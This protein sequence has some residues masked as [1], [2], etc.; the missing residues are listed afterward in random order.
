MV[1]KSP[2]NGGFNRKIHLYFPASHVTRGYSS[3]VIAMARG[4]SDVSLE[5]MGNTENATLQSLLREAFTICCFADK[6]HCM[7]YHDR[8]GLTSSHKNVAR[9]VF[10]NSAIPCDAAPT[11]MMNVQLF[12]PLTSFFLK[13]IS[14]FEHGNA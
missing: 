4:E 12:F 5:G 10:R 6:P 2:A 11:L 8:S 9:K 1:G 14:H 7:S 3:L 13:V